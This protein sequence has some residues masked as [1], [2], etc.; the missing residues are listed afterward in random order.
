MTLDSIRNSCNVFKLSYFLS[1]A[2]CFLRLQNKDTAWYNTRINVTQR[3]LILS[4]TKQKNQLAIHPTPRIQLSVRPSPFVTF[5]VHHTYTC[6]MFSSS[7][8]LTK[9]SRPE[10]LPARSW[11]PELQN[12]KNEKATNNG[13]VSDRIPISTLKNVLVEN[14]LLQN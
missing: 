1:H 5:I 9:S 6:T 10:G 4:K 12:K 7:H 2:H 14:I 3:Y 13:C 8:G 11:A